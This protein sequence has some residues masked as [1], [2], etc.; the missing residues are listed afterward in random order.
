MNG[1]KRMLV[2]ELVIIRKKCKIKKL[3]FYLNIVL[4]LFTSL[5]INY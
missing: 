4:L 1:N 5:I 2:I 3:M